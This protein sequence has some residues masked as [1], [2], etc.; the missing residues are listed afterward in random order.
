MRFRRTKKAVPLLLAVLS[1]AAL[2]AQSARENRALAVSTTQ[3]ELRRLTLLAVDRQNHLIGETRQL[4]GVLAKLPQVSGSDVN[5]CNDLLKFVLDGDPLYANFGVVSLDGNIYCSALPL[6]QPVNASDREWFQKTI[7]SGD[8]SVGEYQIGRITKKATIN[9]GYPL[10]DANGKTQAVLFAALDLAWLNKFAEQAE[11]PPGAT[12]TVVDNKGIILVRHPGTELVGTSA[13]EQ[14]LPITKV[15]LVERGLGIA[16][17][18]GD[19][20]VP[21]LMAFA[22]LREEPQEGFLHL[23]LTVPKSTVTASV[24]KTFARNIS[25][26]TV[27]SLL[28]LVLL[29]F[30]GL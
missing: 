29:R 8:F 30:T 15:N 7:Q 26:L 2:M 24:D 10:K 14:K 17:V 3:Q 18:G 6:T 12:L 20:G 11:L 1:A 9:F 16:E 4:L 27:A 28:S 25:G 22:P 13:P 5:E 21:Y 19:D 23:V